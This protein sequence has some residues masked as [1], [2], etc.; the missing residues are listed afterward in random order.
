MSLTDSH[1]ST[2]RQLIGSAVSYRGKPCVVIEVLEEDASLVLQ[3]TGL[4]DAL[5]ADQYGEAGRHVA[6]VFVLP[7]LEEDGTFHSEFCKLGL[8][9][10]Q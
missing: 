5:Q 4:R 8:S 7:M 9:A 1:K 6:E 2:L 3:A 10:C